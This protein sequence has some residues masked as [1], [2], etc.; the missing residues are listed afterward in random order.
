[1]KTLKCLVERMGMSTIPQVDNTQGQLSGA[2]SDWKIM[3]NEV[4]IL[5][6]APTSHSLLSYRGCK[7]KIFP[8]ITS[9]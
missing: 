8:H 6:K 3:K 4:S 5:W 2:K 7:S 9:Y 1:M